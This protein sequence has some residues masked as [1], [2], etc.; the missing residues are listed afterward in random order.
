MAEECRPNHRIRDHEAFPVVHTSQSS[1]IA[2][3]D[4]NNN[5]DSNDDIQ[6]IDYAL[7]HTQSNIEIQDSSL[8]QLQ[9]N[10]AKKLRHVSPLMI[11]ALTSFTESRSP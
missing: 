3:H 11:K 9:N 5:A 10:A 6:F 7:K 1:T 8:L 2:S 4:M